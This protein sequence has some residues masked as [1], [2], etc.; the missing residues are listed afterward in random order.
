MNKKG[1]VLELMVK[2]LMEIAVIMNIYSLHDRDVV[3]LADYSVDFYSSHSPLEN[4]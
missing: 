4:L 1:H 2:Q 3:V